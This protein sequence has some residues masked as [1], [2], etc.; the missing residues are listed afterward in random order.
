MVTTYNINNTEE[1]MHQSESLFIRNPMPM[2]MYDLATLRFLAVNEAAIRLYGYTKEEFVGMTI[3]DIRP[4]EDVPVLCREIE[5][6]RHGEPHEPKRIWRHRAKD[7]QLIYVEVTAETQSLEGHEARL[8]MVQNV[9]EQVRSQKLLALQKDILENTAKNVSTDFICGELCKGVEVLNPEIRCAVML[10]DLG[11]HRLSLLCAPNLPENFKRE[12]GHSFRQPDSAPWSKAVRSSQTEGF[13]D[14]DATTEY[15]EMQPFLAAFKLRS[16]WAVPVLSAKQEVAALF[17]IYANEPHTLTGFEADCV[18]IATNL[19]SI[20]TERDKS[21]MQLTKFFYDTLEARRA[22][23]EE[24]L[25]NLETVQQS[26]ER[27]R[28]LAENSPDIVFVEQLPE[29]KLIYLNRENIFGYPAEKFAPFSTIHE[30]FVHK[31]DA[32]KLQELRQKIAKTDG[33]DHYNVELRVYNATKQV[34]WVSGRVVVMSRHA[35]GSV[36]QI[37]VNVT[38]ITGQ[39]QIQFSIEK[40]KANLEALIENTSDGIWVVNRNYEIM[41]MN[42]SLQRGCL[43]LLGTQ[44]EPGKNILEQFPQDMREPWKMLYEKAFKGDRYRKEMHFHL[45]DKDLY[46]EISFN[47]I[48]NK[49]GH[50]EGASVFARNITSKKMAAD[51]LVKANFELDSFVYRSSH[52]LRAPLRSVLGLINLVRLEDDSQQ[53]DNYLNLIEK[54]VNRLDNFINDLTHFSRNSRMTVERLKVDFNL[55]LSESV[56]NLRY[57][58]NAERVKLNLDIAQDCDFVS[59]PA[60]ISII[61]HNLI[62]NAVK[63]QRTSIDNSFVSVGIRITV[64]NATIAVTDNGMGIETEYLPKIFDMFFRASANSY[65]SG[66]GLYITKQVVEKLAGS[67]HVESK[68]NEGT[69]FTIVLPNLIAENMTE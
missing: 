60:R 16:C 64:Q 13:A 66:L 14:I 30:W 42:T 9:T 1:A 32:P 31:E 36:S 20:V 4:P 43:A 23:E 54:S 51:E 52:D 65:G 5:R 21:K 3:A 68:V 19:I 59:D 8:V 17:C 2:W 46:Y 18:G 39:K 40:D 38:V 26:E 12:I 22:I 10:Y 69:A 15:P 67:L 7:G 47:P 34:E 11:Q 53:Q 63:Y 49:A 37:L 55:I 24:R 50:V 29:Q 6:I 35:D 57:M 41:I 62:S 28:K 25:R 33:P 44:L 45:Q 48:R 27:F 61:L 56:E 58:E